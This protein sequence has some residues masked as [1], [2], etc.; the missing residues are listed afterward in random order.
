MKINDLI[1]NEI[2]EVAADPI[3]NEYFAD[4]ILPQIEK[5]ETDTSDL[6]YWFLPTNSFLYHAL[7]KYFGGYDNMVKHIRSAVPDDNGIYFPTGGGYNWISADL[8]DGSADGQTEID[9][10]NWINKKN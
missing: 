1:F 7:I 3:S 4:Q 10:L 2:Q 8:L 9:F 5:Q 6:S